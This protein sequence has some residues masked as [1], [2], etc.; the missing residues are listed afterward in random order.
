MSSR[1]QVLGLDGDD[2]DVIGTE[3]P[4]GEHTSFASLL[5]WLVRMAATLLFRNIIPFAFCI[6]ST[7]DNLFSDATT[8]ILL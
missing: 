7:N 5:S 8:H 1:E 3:L 4:Y 6:S 2:G